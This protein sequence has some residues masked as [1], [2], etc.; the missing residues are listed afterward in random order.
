MSSSVI[1]AMNS[2]IIKG[3]CPRD[4][5]VPFRRQGVSPLTLSVERTFAQDVR[6]VFTRGLGRP[7]GTYRGRRI[8]LA[9]TYC[10]PHSIFVC[11]YRGPHLFSTGTYCGPHLLLTGTYRCPYLSLAGTYCGPDIPLA[12]THY[13]PRV[14]DICLHASL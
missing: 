1:S 2:H 9:G 3:L 7:D 12:G 14:I 4:P 6:Y 10:G 8:F 5:P 11:I 13:G